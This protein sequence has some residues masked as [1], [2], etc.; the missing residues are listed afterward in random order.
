MKTNPLIG[1]IVQARMSSQRYPGKVLHNVAGKPMLEYLM[2]RLERCTS[3]NCV[4]V[5]TSSDE[6]D[7]SIQSFC[8]ERGIKCYCGSLT[9]VAGRFKGLVEKYQLD[10][11]VRV[12]GDSPLIDQ[13]LID[14]AVDIFL[15][16]DFDLVTNTLERTYPKGQSIEVLR[17]DTFIKAYESMK[18]DDEFEHVT[19]YF[20]KHP[21]R[22]R[23][24]N[25]ACRENISD[26]QL[27]VDTKEDMLTFEGIVAEMAKPHWEYHLRDILQIY[28]DLT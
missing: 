11:F 3:L 24:R 15:N 28:Y 26:I 7:V 1:A 12:N 13:L 4:F 25:F 8:G 5:A 27:S 21:D 9:D 18:G 22:Y 10:C 14:H 23:I 2:E 17:S 19:K 16:G 6:S 20:Y